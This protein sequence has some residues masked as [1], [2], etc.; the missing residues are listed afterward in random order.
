[1]QISRIKVVL[2]EHLLLLTNMFPE[3]ENFHWGLR[4]EHP[5][6]IV[7]ERDIIFQVIE[8]LI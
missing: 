5:T 4:I 7:I 3:E 8:D 1:M 2:T 6:Y